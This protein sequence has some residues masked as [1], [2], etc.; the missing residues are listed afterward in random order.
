MY[1]MQEKVSHFFFFFWSR[2]VKNDQSR[3][4]IKHDNLLRCC[5]PRYTNPFEHAWIWKKKKREKKKIPSLIIVSWQLDN[6]HFIG[7][8]E[9]ESKMIAESCE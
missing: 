3:G 7:L 4:F 1:G 8:V 6:L 5:L 9:N 2:Q